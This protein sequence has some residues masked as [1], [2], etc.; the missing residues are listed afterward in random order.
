MAPIHQSPRKRDTIKVHM[1]TVM[2]L[3]GMLKAL[4]VDSEH[5]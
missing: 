1:G 3:N 5:Q 4:F 2:P